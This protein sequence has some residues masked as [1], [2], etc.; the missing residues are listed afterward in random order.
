MGHMEAD[1]Q[2]KLPSQSFFWGECSR[3]TQGD[4]N[5]GAWNVEQRKEDQNPGLGLDY[6]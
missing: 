6:M 1:V 2:V 3:I 4:K 5:L